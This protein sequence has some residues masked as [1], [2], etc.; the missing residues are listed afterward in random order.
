LGKKFTIL[1]PEQSGLVIPQ[2]AQSLSRESLPSAAVGRGPDYSPEIDGLRAFAVLSVVLYHFSVP[3]TGGGFIGVDV[4]FVISGFLIGGILWRELESR[5]TLALMSFYARRIRRLAAAYFVMAI[6]T[7]IAAYNILLPFEFREFG[8]ELI[9]STLYSSNIYF[10]LKSGYFDT[11]AESKVLLH[12]WSLSV[13]EQ[14]YILLPP[15]LLLLRRNLKI[16]VATLVALFALS[17][18]LCIAVTRTSHT[19]AFFLI[20]FRAWELLAGV[21]LAIYLSRLGEARPQLPPAV[22]WIGLVMLVVA[23]VLT[24]PGPSFPGIQALLPTAGALLVLV[25]G[26]QDNAVNRLLAQPAVVFIGLISYSLY[27]WHWP[28]LT[29]ARYY[30]GGPGD[31]AETVGLLALAFVLAILSWRFVEQ[32]VRHAAG[33]RPPVL[34]AGAAGMMACLLAAGAVPY[35]G[36]GLPDRFPPAVRAHIDASADFLQDWSRCHVPTSGAL[37]GIEVCPIGPDGAPT[38]VVW[39]DSH[40]RAFEEGLALLARERGKSGF[41]IW[42]AG[43]PPLFDLH[44]KESAATRQ[45]DE[46]CAVANARIRQ[47]IPQLGAV[48][49]LLLIGRWAYYAEGRGI[50]NDSFNTIEIAPAAGSGGGQTD[51]RAVFEAAVLATLQE[52]SKRIPHVLVLRQVP[53]IPTY[54]S[55]DAARRLAHGRLAP[56]EAEAQFTVPLASVVARMEASE[57]PFRKLAADGT[58]TWLDS[59]GGFCHDASCSALR[60]GR[61]LYFDNNHIVNATAIDM[62]H[63][64]DPLVGGAAGA[65]QKD[66]GGP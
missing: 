16:L 21:L 46:D 35:V 64:F 47:A 41:V 24:V 34:L 33:L 56:A 62:R 6:V 3:G 45:Q 31:A 1:P 15:L 14:F 7:L 66:G 65:P 49:T 57:R 11:A 30:R 58:I 32:P 19:A 51:Q 25:N 48:D 36:N 18:V 44:K 4:F 61:A 12:T 37:E 42:R 17:L 20:P 8:K 53:E 2:S 63:L 43:C 26:R 27:L 55:R 59:W 54:D 22:S 52:L 29:L 5:G 39:G 60:N 40:V 38:F 13:E 10:Y 28:V 9:S 50:G 23:T